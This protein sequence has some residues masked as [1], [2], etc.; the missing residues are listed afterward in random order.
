MAT[1]AAGLGT[2]W[3][4]QSNPDRVQNPSQ[5]AVHVILFWMDSCGHCHF[6][7]EEVLPPLQDKYGEKLEI[8]LIE[9][10]STEDID[11]LYLTAETLGINRENVAVPFL[12]IGDQVLIGS[13]QIPTELPGLID[14][15]LTGGGVGF[16]ELEP[17][18]GILPTTIPLENACE[19]GTPC[20]EERTRSTPTSTPGPLLQ[21]EGS[22][23][24]PY[25]AQG[26]SNGFNLAIGVIVWMLASLVYSGFV[27]LRGTKEQ[28]NRAE[29][30]WQKFA[31]PV[32]A[33][34]GL[35][36]AGYLA[37]VET[38]TVEAFCGPIGD[39]NAVQ[40]SPYARLFGVLPIGILGIV[41]F[42]SILATWLVG[43]LSDGQ[44]RENASLVIFGMA[45]IA[46]LFSL[47][48]T[49]LEPFV[50]R[51]VCLWCLGS[52]VIVTLLL[53]FS[54]RPVRKSVIR[55]R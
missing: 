21:V 8:L 46:T 6:V 10:Q 13:K 44:W 2:A 55:K 16:P 31:V 35:G 7:L 42:G 17:L 53:L 23:G 34:V 22:P 25:D 45:L 19:T 51:A 54:V 43:K 24:M 47:Y 15:Y 20:S 39:C 30:G 9:L 14:E 36:I 5:S 27:F 37:Y 48:L 52:A 50:I 29:K 40:S 41:G 4:M 1:R 33:V 38:Q 11:R 3:S 28:V 26:Q 12:I 32:L 18:T 49:Y